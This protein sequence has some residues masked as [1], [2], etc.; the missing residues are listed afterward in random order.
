VLWGAAT[1]DADTP[2]NHLVVFRATAVVAGIS[3]FALI[4]DAATGWSFGWY[5]VALL[6]AILGF[7]GVAYRNWIAPAR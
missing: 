3:L 4:I 5:G 2:P 7:G 1:T 6:A